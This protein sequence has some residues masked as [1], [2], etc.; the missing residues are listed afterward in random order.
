MAQ[1]FAPILAVAQLMAHFPHSWF[2]SGGWAIDL[3]RDRV[4]RDHGDIE[5]G[6]FRDD[7]DALHRHLAGWQLSKAVQAPEG[8]GWVP[9][10]A[11]ERLEP[12]IHQILARPG[13]DAPSAIPEF[14]LFLNERVAGV[15]QFRR[16]PRVTRPVQ[17]IVVHSARGVPIMAPE[18]QLLYK[19]HHH[20]PKDEHDFRGA[21][22]LLSPAQ[23]AWLRDTLV[24]LYPGDRWIDA[25]G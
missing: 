3:F 22:P 7:Q 15:W 21:L 11:G 6:I 23:R 18:I 4:T 14:E 2:V 16:D 1:P 25:L 24:L 8:G 13:E 9:W 5:S 17:T 10:L 12:P 20:L 19:A